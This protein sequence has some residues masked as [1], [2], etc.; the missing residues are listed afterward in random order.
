[1]D[2]MAWYVTV[3]LL[4]GLPAVATVLS[5]HLT[6]RELERAWSGRRLRH[7]PLALDSP[8]FHDC[9]GEWQPL[10]EGD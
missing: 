3:P 9:R 7:P 6:E 5:V 10:P 1:M 2:T 4:V 8:G